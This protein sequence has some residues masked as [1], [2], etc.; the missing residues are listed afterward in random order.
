MSPVPRE[1]HRATC[2]DLLVP[3]RMARIQIL[4]RF[5]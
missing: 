4:G 1:F 2:T 5:R 3:R